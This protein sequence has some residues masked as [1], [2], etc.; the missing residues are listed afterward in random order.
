VPSVIGSR[1]TY[2]LA[3]VGGHCGRALKNGDIIPIGHGTDP[4][5]VLKIPD[6]LLHVNDLKQSV[7][8]IPGPEANQLGTNIITELIERQYIV[9]S[10]S[11][12]MG[13]RLEGSPLSIREGVTNIISSA[14]PA[15]T[16]QLPADGLP[17]ILMADRQTTGGYARIAVVASVD[18]PIVAQLKPGDSIWFQQIGM[19]QAQA[20]YIEQ[21]LALKAL[22]KHYI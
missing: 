8:V 22:T 21:Q 3:N 14:T 16:I 18:L 15:G 20:L 11:N 13:Y 7:R 9:G 5:P 4:P 10:N 17:I 2:L 12:R 1:S 19:E 6:K